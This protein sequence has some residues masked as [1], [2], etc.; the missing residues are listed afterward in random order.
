MLNRSDTNLFIVGAGFAG[1][2]IAQD[3]ARKK[4]FGKVSA[5]LDDDKDLIGKKIDGIPVLGPIDDI[6]PIA[7]QN[8]MSEAIIAM[9]S[10]PGERIREIYELLKRSGILHIRILPAISQV[11]SGT[12]HLVQIRDVNMLDI[13]GRTPIILPLGE[14]LKYLRG[15]RVMITG[16]GGSIG[17]ELARQL[18]TFCKPRAWAKRLKLCR[19]LATSKTARICAT[20][21]QKRDATLFFTARHTSTFQ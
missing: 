11:V 13:L 18:F 16:A 15:K 5:F 2:M 8:A 7:A 3:I 1:Q 9:P 10:A 6:A 14:S 20:L 4:I 21:W 17:S 12:A 19:L